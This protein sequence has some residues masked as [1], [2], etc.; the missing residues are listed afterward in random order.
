M[1]GT[2]IRAIDAHGIDGKSINRGVWHILLP[3]LR[4]LGGGVWSDG[5]TTDAIGPSE[6]TRP[7]GKGVDGTLA[8]YHRGGNA[9]AELG[10]SFNVSLVLSLPPTPNHG[11]DSCRVDGTLACYH[12][13]NNA[14]AKLGPSFL[15]DSVP[16]FGMQ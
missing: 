6:S 7:L 2:T 3:P 14:I 11:G 4:P 8:F 1:D 16:C 13:G 5:C 12:R 10:S 9:I 15:A